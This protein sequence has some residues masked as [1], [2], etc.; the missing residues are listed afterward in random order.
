MTAMRLPA[1]ACLL[2]LTGTPA[3]AERVVAITIDDLPFVGAPLPGD[4]VEA[5]TTRLLAALERH[6]APATGFVRCGS[7]PVALRLVER[8]RNAGMTLGNHTT[9]HVAIDDLT[10]A[11]WERDV[12]ECRTAIARAGGGAT[13]HFRFPFLRTGATTVRRDTAQRRLGALGYIEAPVTIDTA[14]WVIAR[15]Y[16]RDRQAE[17]GR[18]LV[19]H[20][21]IAAEHA[22]AVAQNRFGRAVPQILL[23]HAN[24]LT[25]DHLGA[26]LARLKSAGFRFASLDTVLRDPLY[27]ERDTYAGRIGL[28]WL[29]RAHGTDDAAIEGPPGVPVAERLWAF[30]L[31]QSRALGERF[32]VT[33]EGLRDTGSTRIDHDLLIRAVAPKTFVVVHER[34]FAANSML[35][36]LADGTLMLAGSPYTPE[37]NRR[38]LAW[39]RTRYG[40]RKLLAVATHF[41]VDASGGI[42]AWSEAGARVI[43]SDLTASALKKHGQMMWKSMTGFLSETPHRAIPFRDLVIPP[44]PETFPAA[45]GLVLEHGERVELRYPGPGHTTDN[46]VVWLPARRVLFGGCLVVGMPRLGY[47]G[48]ANLAQWPATMRALLPLQPDVVIPGHGDRTDPGLLEHT[49]RLVRQPK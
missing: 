25:A 27:A 47:L 10:P 30:D 32:G 23:L 44:P 45:Q 2:V 48:D 3:A 49:L 21:A 14:D 17:A 36:E 15:A 6:G 22:V 24:A 26:V 28:S 20:V 35:A 38:L 19:D 11:A 4:T 40:E 13:R 8:W 5:A 18:A 41:H 16:T 34:P 42:P 33:S 12:V 31:G 1:L 9:S 7:D 37:A 39:L 29:Y 43:G 46:I